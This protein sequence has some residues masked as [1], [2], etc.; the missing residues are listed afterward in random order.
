MHQPP[1][2]F[3]VNGAAIRDRR[4]TAGL[5]TRELADAAGI[6]R[7]YLN[8]LENGSRTRMRPGKYARLRTALN[9]SDQELLAQSRTPPPKE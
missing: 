6:S 3:E 4:K 2:T 8:H 9:A 1:T 5:E 7:R